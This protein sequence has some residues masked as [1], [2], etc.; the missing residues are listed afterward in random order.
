MD[1]VLVN[2]FEAS[3]LTF[4]ISSLQV[5]FSWLFIY[6]RADVKALSKELEKSKKELDTLQKNDDFKDEKKRAKRIKKLKADI[7]YI[8]AQ[9]SRKTVLVSMI[10]M[11]S[12]FIFNRS[13]AS[14]FEGKVCAY[15]PFTPFPFLTKFT[16]RGLE[17]SDMSEAGFTFIYWATFSL[18]KDILTN[19]FGFAKHQSSPLAMLM[20]NSV[21]NNK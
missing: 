6:R 13:C 5:F 18:F 7:Q 4:L 2:F 21:N 8:G 19:I 17:S 15:L 9:Y 20:Q 1:S 11:A 14:L 3:G 16:H 10:L 12:S